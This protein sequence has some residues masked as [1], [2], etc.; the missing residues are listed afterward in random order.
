[1]FFSQLKTLD[2][3]LS[4]FHLEGRAQEFVEP[5]PHEVSAHL[6]Q[7]LQLIRRLGYGRNEYEVAQGVIFPT[8][9]EVWTHYVD[10]LRVWGEPTFGTADMKGT[11]D[12]VISRRAYPGQLQFTPPYVVV[13][14]AKQEKFDESW[15]QGVA[16]MVA[17][18]ELNRPAE[19]PIYGIVT[20]GWLW[21]F[22]RLTGK[23]F[24]QEPGRYSL[25]DLPQLCGALR[26]VF[27]QASLCSAPPPYVHPQAA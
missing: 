18:Q 15:G 5:M 24:H 17:A 25:D 6:I 7:Q 3:A 10:L 11:T 12:Y 9:Q 4:A 19:Y 16:A 2:E 20:I 21:E 26:Y 13:V 23:V 8:L 27:E 22:G 14:E 1:M